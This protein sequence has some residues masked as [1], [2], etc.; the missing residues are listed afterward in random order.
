MTGSMTEEEM[1]R[2]AMEEAKTVA[3][4]QREET[5]KAIED[6]RKEVMKSEKAPDT[7]EAPKKP[8]KAVKSDYA[9]VELSKTKTVHLK[10]WTGKTKKRFKKVFEGV[11][12]MEDVDFRE[13]LEVLIY[14]QSKE[15]LLFQ[16]AE[17]QFLLVK[18]REASI[19]N[20]IISDTSC[21][22]CG[23]EVKIKVKTEDLNDFESDKLPYKFSDEIEF[24]N[25]SKTEAE[26]NITVV[27]NQP[28]F[29][30][31]TSEA[32]IEFA[33]RIKIKDKSIAEVIDYIDDLKISEQNKLVS[34]MNERLSK[35]SLIANHKCEH[36]KTE[37]PFTVDVITGVF[38]ALAK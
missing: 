13:V 36:C 19:G 4:T 33:S 5:K 7:K 23:S 37:Q 11:S 3:A 38:E 32:D 17:Q 6:A 15:D 22:N 9:T 14:N 27:M 16:E 30:G 12:S 25:C 31:L 34:A 1:T 8:I 26:D 28:D 10:P 20:E 21:P 24:K 35:Y 2:R 18:L 29:D